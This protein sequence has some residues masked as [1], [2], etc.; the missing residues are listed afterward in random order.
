MQPGIRRPYN[1]TAAAHPSSSAGPDGGSPRSGWSLPLCREETRYI[2]GETL[3]VSA[4]QSTTERR[5]TRTRRS[6]WQ[7]VLRARLL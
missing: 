2:T 5:L 7:D 6:P 1:E 4:G 3:A